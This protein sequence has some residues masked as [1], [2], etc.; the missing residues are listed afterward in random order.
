MC[1]HK[2]HVGQVKTYLVGS[3]FIGDIPLYHKI[4]AAFLT[5]EYVWRLLYL[6]SEIV[7]NLH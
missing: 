3:E 1:E 6:L 7:Y 2:L 4:L 5:G